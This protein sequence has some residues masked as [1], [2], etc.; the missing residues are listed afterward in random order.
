M[1]PQVRMLRRRVEQMMT[2][3]CAISR[4]G[5][6]TEDQWGSEIPGAPA[7]VYLGKCHIVSTTKAPDV[8]TTTTTRQYWITS[9]T[10]KIPATDMAIH[11]SDSVTIIRSWGSADP[12][13]VG[14]PMVVL[15]STVDEW[16][17]VQEL[18]CQRVDI[19]S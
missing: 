8:V 9:C 19:G 16:Q 4:M 10:V 3:E 2:A 14:A 12:S 13:L 11:P 18:V 5:E 6:P 17:T 1:I 15:G 7:V